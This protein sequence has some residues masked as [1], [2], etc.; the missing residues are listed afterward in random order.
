[1]PSVFRAALDLSVGHCYGPRP[2]LNG[3]PNVFANGI[4]IVRVGDDYSQ[5]HSCGDNS[6]G[7]GIASTGSATVKINGRPA[8]R[9]GDSVACGDVAGIGSP[10][11]FA[12]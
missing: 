3:S 4:A 7:M 6:H 8:H 5:V 9:T 1:M 12:G 2:C 10:D 11:V